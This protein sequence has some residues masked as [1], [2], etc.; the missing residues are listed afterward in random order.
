MKKSTRTILEFDQRQ[1]EDVAKLREAFS[2]SD[3]K[4]ISNKEIFLIAMGF[5]FTAKNKLPDFKNS[6]T[7]VRLEYFDA[8]DD[9][10]FA[11]L[12]VTE[13]NDEK[14]LLEIEALYDLAQLY[15]GGGIAILLE[16]LQQETDF[17]EWFA[18]HVVTGLKSEI[19]K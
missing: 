8:Q 6:G 10:L 4:V 15:A 14:S 17:N 19:T 7:G 11:A 12:Q 1:L 18:S 16:H 2:L 3:G 9:V 5:G 13:T